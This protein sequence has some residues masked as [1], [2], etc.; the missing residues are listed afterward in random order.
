MGKA[1]EKRT[2]S[3]LTGCC[4]EKYFPFPPTKNDSSSTSEGD[5]FL[6]MFNILAI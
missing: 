1:K 4:N 2:V 5:V 3:R 6:L